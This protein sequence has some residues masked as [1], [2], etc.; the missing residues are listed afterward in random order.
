MARPEVINL[1]CFTS[2]ADPMIPG[3]SDPMIQRANDPIHLAFG[4]GGLDAH[5][6]RWIGS[7]AH[8]IIGPCIGSRVVG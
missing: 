7:L 2:F 6:P 5:R 8:C 3:A 1:L 4:L